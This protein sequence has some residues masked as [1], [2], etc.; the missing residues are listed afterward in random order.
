ML[1]ILTD[2]SSKSIISKKILKFFKSND[3]D[4]KIFN[5]IIVRLLPYLSKNLQYDESINLS[6]IGIEKCNNN[7]S[8]YLLEYLYYGLIWYYDKIGDLKKRDENIVKCH[9]T[10]IILN[11]PETYNKFNK[12][13]LKKLFCYCFS[14]FLIN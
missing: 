6:L 14:Y 11:N 13:F 5:L 1:D 4:Y 7:F 2:D 10:L 9:S 8:Y 3:Y 12:L